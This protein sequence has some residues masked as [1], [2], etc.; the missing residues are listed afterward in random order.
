MKVE[1]INEDKSKIMKRNQE[2]PKLS[3]EYGWMYK[4]L[5]KQM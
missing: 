1:Q 3:S 5:V 4:Y 2:N